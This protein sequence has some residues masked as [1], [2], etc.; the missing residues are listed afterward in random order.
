MKSILHFLAVVFLLAP[1]LAAQ[2][3]TTEP[4]STR[5]CFRTIG[6]DLDRA[7]SDGVEVFSRPWRF[8]STDALYTAA[9]VGF[10]A[11]C[12]LVDEQ[13]RE[14]MQRNQLSSENILLEIGD[15]YGLA[16]RAV[17]LGGASYIGGLV[18]HEP[19]FRRTGR[20]ILESVAFAGVLT[21]TLKFL[22]GRA[23]PYMDEGAFSYRAFQTTVDRTSLPSGHATVAF[24]VST[25]MA[26]EIGSPVA[27]VI[28]YGMA[29]ITAWQ[30][31][32]NDRHWF[33]DTVL[34]AAIG[35]TM[36]RVVVAINRDRGE[37]SALSRVFIYPVTKF[38]APGAGVVIA[39]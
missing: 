37:D 26:E 28:L 15:S 4:D 33:S 30:R 34:G 31:I 29:G 14:V 35:F 21:I 39:F 3:V 22:L 32:H 23:R 10:T 12:F 25:V 16:Q 36:G 38:G 17:V 11:A 7:L 20:E 1:L 18:F 27:S 13:F 8:S 19:A 24:A 9:V 2:P 6:D 5:G